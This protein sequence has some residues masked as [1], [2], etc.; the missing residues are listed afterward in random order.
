MDDNELYHHGILGMKWGIRRFQ[1]KDGSLTTSGRKRYSNSSED[2]N[3][4]QN[5][6]K[7]KLNE[8]SNAELRKLNERQQLERTYHQFNKSRISKGIALVSSAVTVTTTAINLY[9]NSN[10]IIEL[11]RKTVGKIINTET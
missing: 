8:M 1:K 4:T 11:G 5:L 7:K 2:Y 3:T 10:K 6:K 9:N